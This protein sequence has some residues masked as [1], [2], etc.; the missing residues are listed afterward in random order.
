MRSMH[1]NIDSFFFSICM[2]PQIFLSKKMM[3]TELFLLNRNIIMVLIIYL[4]YF[5]PVVLLS[6]YLGSGGDIIFYVG[7]K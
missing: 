1:E 4:Q 5:G 2:L 6:S 3:L 7:P